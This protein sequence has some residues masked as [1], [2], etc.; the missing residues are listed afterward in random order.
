MS[1]GARIVQSVL[2]PGYKLADAGFE[3]Q[4]GRRIFPR[5]CRP[6]STPPYSKGIR[7]YFPRLKQLRCENSSYHHP[8]QF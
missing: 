8:N 1:F 5:T 6:A 2:C 3:T 4:K 7:V